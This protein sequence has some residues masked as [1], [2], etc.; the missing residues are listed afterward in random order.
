MK[1]QKPRILFYDIETLHLGV[2]TFRLGKQVVRHDSLQPSRDTYDIICIQYMWAGDKKVTNL[3]WI[4]KYKDSSKM[5]ETF[6]KLVGKA[7]MLIG[8]NSDRFDSKHVNTQRMLKGLAPIPNWAMPKTRDD[9][10]KQMRQFFAL[11]SYSL[12][13]LCKILFGSGKNSM[14]FQDWRD[15]RDYKEMLQLQRD[16]VRDLTKVCKFY[17]GKSS[18]DV[19]KA[20]KAA[21]KKMYE[22]GDKDTL[23][24]Y[25]AWKRIEPYIKPKLN[26]SKFHKNRGSSG[27]HCKHCGSTDL[28]KNGKDYRGA[29]VKQNFMCHNPKCSGH[30]GR[31][32][33]YAGQATIKKNGTFGPL[34]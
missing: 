24:T 8:K 2:D 26:M 13:Y 21:L 9:M 23:D 20:G 5:I 25:N 32:A 6:D 1:D 33:G 27:L 31:A 19:K 11:P 18:I 34:E 30:P 29:V 7:D 14:K 16:G 4:G 15:I 28:T 22:Y 3:N 10:E 12:D 17:Y